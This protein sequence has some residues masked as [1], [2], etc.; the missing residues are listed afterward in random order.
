MRENYVGKA[1]Q[2][3]VMAEYLLRGYN[4]AMPEVD[5]GD[6]LFVVEDADGEMWRV[7]VKTAIATQRDYGFSG[8]FVVPLSQ[9]VKPRRPELHFVFALRR[10]DGWEFV[11]IP[12]KILKTEYEDYRAGSRAGDAVLFY[13]AFHAGGLICSG[14]DWQRFRGNWS[15]W[16]VISP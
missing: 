14:R 10:G 12:R 13:L 5:R 3:A 6:D 7:Q 4:V 8:R 15:L 2:L 16:P 11:P 9:L 1:G